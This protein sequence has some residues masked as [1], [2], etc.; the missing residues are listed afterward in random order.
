VA[1]VGGVQQRRTRRWLRPTAP[2]RASIVAVVAAA[3]TL[4]V[5]VVVVVA[6]GRQ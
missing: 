2:A 4:R 1:G 5:I 3:A 6:G